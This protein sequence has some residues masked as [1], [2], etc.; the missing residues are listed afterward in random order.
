VQE[1][2]PIRHRR[3]YVSDEQTPDPNDKP[4]SAEEY[5]KA[6]RDGTTVGDEW[7]RKRK[8]QQGE[9]GEVGEAGDEGT[10]SMR[11]L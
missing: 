7:E 1:A 8:E 6:Q 4:T 3:C 5:R 10:R 9:R 2:I 11:V